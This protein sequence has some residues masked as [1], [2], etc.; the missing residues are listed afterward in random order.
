M[1]SVLRELITKSFLFTST[2][3]KTAQTDAGDWYFP[4]FT[5]WLLF[6][7]H[8]L[9]MDFFVC[10]WYMKHF[11]V[12]YN[13]SLSDPIFRKVDRLLPPYHL[14]CSHSCKSLWRRILMAWQHDLQTVPIMALLQ[15]NRWEVPSGVLHSPQIDWTNPKHWN[16]PTAQALQLEPVQCKW[17]DSSVP[18]IPYV[19][20]TV[21]GLWWRSSGYIHLLTSSI[22]PFVKQGSQHLIFRYCQNNPTSTSRQLRYGPFH[23]HSHSYA[24]LS[25]RLL[26]LASV[27]CSTTQCYCDFLSLQLRLC[28]LFA[29]HLEQIAVH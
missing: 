22:W 6:S 10:K 8:A 7:G 19:D 21:L 11:P 24:V 14:S 29:E 2:F 5:I 15:L 12:S 28:T 4:P 20:C 23:Q 16:A 26:N 1:W 9:S 27:P 25:T 3:W 18:L 13:L 17:W